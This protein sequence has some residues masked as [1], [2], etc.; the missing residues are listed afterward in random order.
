MS[1]MPDSVIP[2]TRVFTDLLLAIDRGGHSITA[3]E[4]GDVYELADGIRLT[5]LGPVGDYN[6]IN[7]YSIVARLDY[8]GVSFL[9]TGDV[10]SRGERDLVESGQR[11]RATV[12]DVGHHGL[13]TSSTRPQIVVISCGIDN[14][15]GHPARAAVE[16]LQETGAQILRTDLAGTIVIS[17]DGRELHIATGR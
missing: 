9:F 15:Y 12:L 6:D 10:E 8:A 4:P 11:L 17:T 16:R 2:T 1:D 3:A 5:I 14:S 13:N 7:N